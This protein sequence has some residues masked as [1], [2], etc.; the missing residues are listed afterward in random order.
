MSGNEATIVGDLEILKMMHSPPSWLSSGFS[1]KSLEKTI[2]TLWAQKCNTRSPSCYH[3]E[4]ILAVQLLK[5][6]AY[7]LYC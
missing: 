6:P 3:A 4:S 7:F 5:L 2:K 1:N